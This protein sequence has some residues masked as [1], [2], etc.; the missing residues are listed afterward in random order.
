MPE[1]HIGICHIRKTPFVTVGETPIAVG[2][3]NP[4]NHLLGVLRAGLATG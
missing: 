3:L 4:A 2:D 1:M